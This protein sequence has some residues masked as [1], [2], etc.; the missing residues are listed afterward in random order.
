MRA[1]LNSS[2]T[3]GNV[4]CTVAVEV[5]HDPTS[6]TLFGV[7]VTSGPSLKEVEQMIDDAVAEV[8]AALTTRFL[9]RSYGAAPA[10]KED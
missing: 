9:G 2:R 5:D 7:S 4:A 8:K 6:N 1:A 10:E 3:N